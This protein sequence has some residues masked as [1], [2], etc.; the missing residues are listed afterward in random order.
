[1]RGKSPALSAALGL[2]AIPA[3]SAVAAG[4][5]DLVLR[6]GAVYTVDGVRS[7]AEALAVED[8]RIRYVGTGAGA[9]EFIGEE[10][11]V[12]DLRGRMVLPG[13]QDAHVHP[14][15]A[16]VTYNQC[17]LFG[18]TSKEELVAKVKQC[19]EEDPDSEWIRGG[20]WTLDL[21]APS[22]V[23]DKKLLDGMVSDR[24]V[25]L[26]SSDGHSLWVNSRALEV[27][28]IGADTPDPERGRIDRYPGTT[29]PSGSL[30]EDSG[31]MLVTSH[32]PKLTDRELADGLRYAVRLLN[33]FGITAVQD[34][35]VKL[36]SDDAYRGFPAYHA[37]TTRASSRFASSPPCTGRT[38]GTS[39]S[40]WPA[41]SRRVGNT[42]GARSARR[43]SRSGRTVCSRRRRPP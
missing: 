37:S 39:R 40:R 16:G 41:S 10:T 28:G 18:L 34:A 4:L 5:A 3:S 30:Q 1:M 9:S 6:N 21:F 17:A 14:V 31:M 42:R 27:A 29:E 2:L 36:E 32:E 22:G 20:G 33:G 15:H 8:G 19:A 25:S 35:I 11:R 26:E 23:P 38:T 7:W 13:F 12:V 43:P 24:P